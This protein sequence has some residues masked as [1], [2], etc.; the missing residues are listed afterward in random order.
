MKI[1]QL[2]LIA[3]IILTNSCDMSE[4]SQIERWKQEI[5]ETEQDF[6]KMSKESG[7]HKAFM[8]YAAD[9][10][11]LM[12]NNK[13]IIGKDSIDSHFLAQKINNDEVQLSWEPDFIEVSS[14]G[15]LGYTYGKYNYKYID[16]DGNPAESN[17][18]FHTIWKRQTN[19]IWKFV[20]D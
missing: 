13:L 10:A 2:L 3:L 1:G 14:S 15:D 6:A 4:E 8:E 9:N 20:W 11:V 7:I 19:G 5:L 17:G 16:A 18:V 12:R